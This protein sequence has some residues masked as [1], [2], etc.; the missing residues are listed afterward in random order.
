[1]E[2][3]N[4]VYTTGLLAPKKKSVDTNETV[5]AALRA[6]MDTLL[7]KCPRCHEYKIFIFCM[8]ASRIVFLAILPI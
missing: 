6:R 2:V 5:L 4:Q 7:K 8:F 3:N 1:M